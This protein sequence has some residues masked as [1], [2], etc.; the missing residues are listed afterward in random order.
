VNAPR[1]TGAQWTTRSPARRREHQDEAIRVDEHVLEAE[2]AEGGQ[3]KT[4]E[5]AETHRK[6]SIN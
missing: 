4:Q 6:P 5:A 1:A 2:I 3:K